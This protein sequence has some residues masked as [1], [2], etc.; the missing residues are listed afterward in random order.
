LVWHNVLSFD[1]H[2][3]T[4]EPKRFAVNQRLRYFPPRRLDNPSERRAG[5]LHL[6]RRRLLVQSLQVGQA[7]CFNFIERQRHLFQHA[8]RY[9]GGLEV[10]RRGCV[11][12]MS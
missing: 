12:D 5:N 3:S 11:I 9:A 2:G 8:G 6:L 10:D 4:F 7:Q 1:Y